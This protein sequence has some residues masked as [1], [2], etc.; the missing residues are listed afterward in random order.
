MS[1]FE[2]KVNFFVIVTVWKEIYN[3]NSGGLHEP[4]EPIEKEGTT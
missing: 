2:W 1:I 3:V 4:T